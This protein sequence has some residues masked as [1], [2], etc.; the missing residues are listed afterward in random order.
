[1]GKLLKPLH[2]LLTL[3]GALF[4][5]IL[6]AESFSIAASGTNRDS[7]FALFWTGTLIATVPLL[8]WMI[9]RTKT[10]LERTFGLFGFATVL[11]LPKIL[12]SPEYPL[13]HDEYAHLRAVEDILTTGFP[14]GFNSIVTPVPDFPGMHALTAWLASVANLE[15]WTAALVVT[16]VG[17]ILITVGIYALISILGFSYQAA[18]IGTAI[19]VTNSNFMYFHGQFG[20]ETVGLPLAIWTLIVAI[21]AIQS[22]RPRKWIFLLLIAPMSYALAAVHHLSAVGLIF[23]LL[24][25]AIATTFHSITKKEYKYALMSWGVLAVAA[26]FIY[27]RFIPTLSLLLEYLGSPATRGATQLQDIINQFLG[28]GGDTNTSRTLFEGSNLPMFERVL[29]FGAT[30]IA[31]LAVATLILMWVYSKLKTPRLWHIPQGTPIRNALAFLSILYIFSV[32]FILTA[33]GAEGARRSWGYTFIGVALVFAILFEM[34]SNRN[35]KKLV[36]NKML[37]TLI[38]IPIWSIMLIGGVAAGVNETYRFP[39]PL[40][41]VSDLTASTKEAQQLGLWFKNNV[42]VN[43]WVAADRYSGMQVGSIGMAQVAPASKSFPYWELYWNTAEPRP[44][45]IAA[46][47]AVNVEYIVVDIRMEK[48][49]PENGFWFET[50]E[51]RYPRGEG[52]PPAEPQALAKFDNMSIFTKVFSTE[53]YRIYKV[54]YDLYNPYQ[55][56][57]ELKELYDATV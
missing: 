30:L 15:A 52:L 22:P 26:T 37:P 42:A 29:S 46:M 18:A 38:F 14:G 39:E 44:S 4:G 8:L 54:N 53:H 27:I 57:R 19:Y 50:G 11:S 43:T 21:Y 12:R 33:S 10:P 2:A 31:G 41:R 34:W 20:Y 55:V 40:D 47:R 35:Q 5:A 56:E 9:G 32:P 3:A 36:S 6:I 17:H 24:L 48:E 13:F 16:V 23:M 25:I 45:L 51:P 7:M 1:M 49:V 28:V